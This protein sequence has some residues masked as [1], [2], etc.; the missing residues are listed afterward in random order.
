MRAVD[1]W[2]RDD[3]HEEPSVEHAPVVLPSEQPL[4]LQSSAVG[5]Q[6][7]SPPTRATLDPVFDRLVQEVA[8]FE[9]RHRRRV[10]KLKL[11]VQGSSPL[12]VV[13][14]RGT[15]GVDVRFSTRDES[16]RRE[17]RRRRAELTDRARRNGVPIGRVRVD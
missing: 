6:A 16:L 15:H 14:R 4:E 17:L 10:L 8:V 12:D 7:P 13:L 3:A 9:D 11:S 2:R 1:A 5:V